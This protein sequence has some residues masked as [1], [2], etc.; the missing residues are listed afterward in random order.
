[1]TYSRRFSTH[2]RFVKQ[3]LKI[4]NKLYF[5]PVF[6]FWFSRKLRKVSK[7]FW[8]DFYVRAPLYLTFYFALTLC[9]T[10]IAAGLYWVIPLGMIYL[11][12]FDVADYCS[13]F[14]NI[15]N[16]INFYTFQEYD[17][18]D[19]KYLHDPELITQEIFKIQK[20]YQT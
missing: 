11:K 6:F 1:M 3:I 9:L 8:L 19:K 16:I 5:L 12:I 7:K 17:A 13:W 20:G 14:K 18:H 4:W 2:N 10:Q 15:K